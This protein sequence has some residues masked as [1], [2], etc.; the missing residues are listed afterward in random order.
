MLE[1]LESSF[2]ARKLR[3][4]R[5]SYASGSRY[6][7]AD[8]HREGG[9]KKSAIK[10]EANSTRAYSLQKRRTFHYRGLKQ[11]KHVETVEI[12]CYRPPPPPLSSYPPASSRDEFER[13]SRVKSD[14]RSSVHDG[15]R[16]HRYP[17]VYRSR[18]YRDGDFTW[19]T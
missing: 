11:Q 13:K 5:V 8:M 6:E 16:K 9:D 7:I 12:L 18:P 15:S 3:D 17:R 1:C 4:I 14:R 2:R 19:R 10:V